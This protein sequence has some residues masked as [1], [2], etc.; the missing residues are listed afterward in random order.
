MAAMERTHRR[1]EDAAP[2]VRLVRQRALRGSPNLHYSSSSQIAWRANAKLAWPKFF[3][4]ARS[5]SDRNSEK[6]K[7][8]SAE[9]RGQTRP[10]S[11]P[12]N[13]GVGQH[14]PPPPPHP[15]C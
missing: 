3:Q 12:T 8:R 6:E 1:D 7:A 10:L 14:T 9:R 5:A 4:P 11:S 15:V 13:K 2:V